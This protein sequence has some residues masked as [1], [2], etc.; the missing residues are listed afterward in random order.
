MAHPSPWID[1]SIPI[2]PK[3]ATWPDNPEVTLSRSQCLAHGDV[4]N[5]SEL[6]LGTHT[7]TH[8]DGINHFI[9]GAPGVDQMP[10]ELMT[11][12]AR[13][14]EIQHPS[15]ITREEIEPFDL[16]GGE[17]V[18]F[19]SRNSD[20]LHGSDDFAKDFVHVGTCA[21]EYLAEIGISL[22]GVDYLSVGGFEGNVVAVHKALLGAGIWCVE[23][24]NLRELSA[25]SYE[26]LCLPIR[27]VDGDGGLTRALARRN[28]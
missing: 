28:K 26:F 16:Q 22:I 10:L 7:G 1:L 12:D 24:L 11:G 14:I 8:I 4:C 27:L 19:R 23:G 9:K 13:V 3:M 25:G 17:R 15:Q 18:L 21:A 6:R 20:D 5:V 2:H